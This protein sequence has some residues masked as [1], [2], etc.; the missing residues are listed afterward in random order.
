MVRRISVAP[1]IGFKISTPLL[2]PYGKYSAG[3]SSECPPV[4][5]VPCRSAG[6]GGRGDLVA[7]A[8]ISKLNT[9]SDNATPQAVPCLLPPVGA[10]SD[11]PRLLPVLGAVF[12][13]LR[14]YTDIC[15]AFGILARSSL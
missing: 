12:P 11:P 1:G 5:W 8:T 3:S 6:A 4:P 13:V 2:H 14:R 10:F 9:I 15:R 7:P